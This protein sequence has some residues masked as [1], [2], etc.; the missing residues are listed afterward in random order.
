[1]VLTGSFSCCVFFVFVFVFVF[2][3]FFQKARCVQVG[4][5]SSQFNVVKLRGAATKGYEVALIF[6]CASNLFTGFLPQVGGIWWNSTTAAVITVLTVQWG[7][8]LQYC[9]VLYCTVLYS[10]WP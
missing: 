10:R 7:G 1:M 4:L 6:S 3:F 5:R 9:T 8:P 2:F